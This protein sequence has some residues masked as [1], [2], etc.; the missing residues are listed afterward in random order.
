MASLLGCTL[1]DHKPTARFPLQEAHHLCPISLQLSLLFCI[2]TEHLYA[3]YLSSSGMYGCLWSWV[4]SDC[5]SAILYFINSHI[6]ALISWQHLLQAFSGT[7]QL[8]TGWRSWPTISL[9]P[10]HPCQQKEPMVTRLSPFAPQ[11][12]PQRLF[13][14]PQTPLPMLGTPLHISGKFLH[15]QPLQLWPS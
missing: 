5:G 9:A 4:W 13:S 10:T 12:S 2:P 6:T 15:L 1:Q 7:L 8:L 14:H 3:A 11:K